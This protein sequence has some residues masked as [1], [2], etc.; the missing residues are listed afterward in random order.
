M[1]TPTIA[2]R[3]SPSRPLNWRTLLLGGV[4]AAIVAAVLVLAL[5][6]TTTTPS[7]SPRLA[8]ANPPAAVAAYQSDVAHFGTPSSTSSALSA[9]MGHR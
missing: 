9:G 6:S 3:R 5:T 8:P 1:S 7:V 4:I 2:A